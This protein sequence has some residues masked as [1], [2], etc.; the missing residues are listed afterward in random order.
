VQYILKGIKDI[1]FVYL[2]KADVVRH[3]I[4]QAVVRA[5]EEYERAHKLDDDARR[6]K[7]GRKIKKDEK[8]IGES[9]APEEKKA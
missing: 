7:A 9:T 8:A 1:A 4:I 6:R 2:T 3:R 5:Y